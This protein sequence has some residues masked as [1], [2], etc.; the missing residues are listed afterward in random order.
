MRIAAR[1]SSIA[2][3]MTKDRLPS[4]ARLAFALLGALSCGANS[5]GGSARATLGASGAA[6]ST[7]AACV[8]LAP[9]RSAAHPEVRVV[10]G[11]MHTCVLAPGGT[12]SCVGDNRYRQ[13]GDG[14][15]IPSD[16]PVRVAGLDAVDL[17]AD[18]Y[19]NCA[20]TVP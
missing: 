9:T 20:R 1:P 14:T 18:E 6:P 4:M 7:E 12:V 15:W 19:A 2:A 8:G 13:L 17:D 3:R 16:V 11:L 5:S 10:S